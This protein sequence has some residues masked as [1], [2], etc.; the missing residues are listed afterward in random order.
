MIRYSYPHSTFTKISIFLFSILLF[1]Y[2]CKKETD[3]TPPTLQLISENGF[4]TDSTVVP[5]GFPYRIGITAG[6]GEA[7]ITN[8]VVTLTTENGMETA[9]DSGM[10]SNDFTYTRSISYGAS[11]FEK[12]SFTL[13]DK[14]GKSA[15]TSITILKDE[16][17]VFGP[18]TTYS[19]IKLS[20]QDDAGGNSFFSVTN[21]SLYSQLTAEANQSDINLITYFGDKLVPSTEFTLSSPGESDVATFYPMIANWSIP[22]NETRYK[23]DSLSISPGA[24]DAAYNDSLII[25]NYTSATIGKRKFKIVRAGYIIPFQVTIGP[26]SGKRGLI[27]IKSIQEGTGGHIIADIKVQK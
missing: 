18:I 11:K 3:K 14:N 23:P 25:T 24:F 19:S 6:K 8:L 4:V 9:L 20:A 16:T 1:A 21:G 10:Y 7:A 2:A 13:R 5:I 22:K 15:N 27:K 12:W 26:S 17:S